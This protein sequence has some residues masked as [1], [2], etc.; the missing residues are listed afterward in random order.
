MLLSVLE[1]PFIMGICQMLGIPCTIGLLYFVLSL[2]EAMFKI[3]LKIIILTLC[4]VDMEE[5]KAAIILKK[6]DKTYYI[7]N[8]DFKRLKWVF[9]GKGHSDTLDVLSE[10]SLEVNH[11]E[12]VGVIGP[13][14]AGKSTLL[15]IIAGI[16]MPT[17]GEMY[18][19]GKVGSLINLNAG[20]NQEF[21]GRENIYYKGLL[22]GI[23]KEHLDIIM[24]EIIEFVDIGD[25]FDRPIKTYSSGMTAR[26]GFALA[27][28]SDPDIL[29][30]DEVFS[31]GDA[32]FRDK[33]KEKTAEMFKSGKSV[34]FTS[35]SESL[36]REFCHR[37][38]YID[39][40]RIQFEGDVEEGLRIYNSDILAKKRNG[41]KQ[42]GVRV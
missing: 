30:V 15:K 8:K 1:M 40:G 6:L 12:I 14:G 4:K 37:V 3:N 22:L 42:K 29:L 13:N 16:S 26:L 41:K 9:S 20:F 17:N 27:V 21:T 38:I 5:K 35:H 23:T 34:L 7:F 33:S 39:H 32:S 25:Y 36:I 10:I 24:N 19:E 28:Y 18:I 31:V 2:L 11:G